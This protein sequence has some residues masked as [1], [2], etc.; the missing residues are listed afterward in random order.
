MPTHRCCMSWDIFV[1]SVWDRYMFFVSNFNVRF[2]CVRIVT[3]AHTH[4]HVFILGHIYRLI[5]N[6]RKI[7][8]ISSWLCDLSGSVSV[9]MNTVDRPFRFPCGCG[10]IGAMSRPQRVLSIPHVWL[11]KPAMEHLGSRGTFAGHRHRT[12]F[13]NYT[14]Q[15]II[16]CL[17]G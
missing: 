7:M 13:G 17:N 9:V 16:E 11:G 3:Y 5:L 2:V 8:Q 15:R 10:I 6:A 14:A 12:R 1:G 4:I